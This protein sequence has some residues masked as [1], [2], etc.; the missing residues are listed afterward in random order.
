MEDDPAVAHDPDVGLLD[1]R[2]VLPVA[3][4]GADDA[5]VAVALLEL[6][7]QRSALRRL[8]EA[9]DVAPAQPDALVDEVIKEAVRVPAE[10]ELVVPDAEIVEEV[11]VDRSQR[12]IVRHGEVHGI[13]EKVIVEGPVETGVE[14]VARPPAEPVG[15]DRLRTGQAVA[16]SGPGASR[17]ADHALGHV[18]QR[19]GHVDREADLV[20]GDAHP[21]VLEMS[22]GHVVADPIDE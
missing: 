18:L 12:E 20:I 19:E 3:V 1:D 13:A 6:H 11:E 14:V 9:V 7:A 4:A 2:H 8:A 17:Q 22:D 10:M 15:F 21:V 5:T 16:A